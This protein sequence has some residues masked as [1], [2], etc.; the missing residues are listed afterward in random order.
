MLIV[1]Y[2]TILYLLTWDYSSDITTLQTL[3]HQI[4]N[5][6]SNRFADFNH[7]PV[8][9]QFHVNKFKRLFRNFSLYFRHLLQIV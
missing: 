5:L 3:D 8:L 2:K 9:E 6:L 1:I 4:K 7:N